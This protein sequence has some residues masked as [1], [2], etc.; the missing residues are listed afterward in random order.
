MAAVLEPQ[1]ELF[2]AVAGDLVPHNLRGEEPKIGRECRAERLGQIVHLLKV[3]DP[4]AE[5]PAA[6]LVGAER[7]LSVLA[8]P[9]GQFRATQIGNQP[10]LSR[11][12]HHVLDAQMPSPIVCG[13]GRLRV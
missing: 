10:S 1:Q 3:G 11:F 5:N 2:R 4:L 7:S 8:A 13:P 6:N 12:R 9:L